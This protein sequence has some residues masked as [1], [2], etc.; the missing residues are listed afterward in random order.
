MG[1]LPEKLLIICGTGC[2]GAE[3]LAN[4]NLE[5][6]SPPT[7]GCKCLQKRHWPSKRYA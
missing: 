6:D 7:P 1:S 4:Y 3:P 2:A 5:F